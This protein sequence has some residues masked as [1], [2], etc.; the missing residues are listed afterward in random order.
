MRLAHSVRHEVH[1]GIC[2]YLQQWYIRGGNEGVEHQ[3]VRRLQPGEVEP[4]GCGT[5]RLIG[6]L[7]PIAKVPEVAS[8]V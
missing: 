6:R 7:Q 2:K 4:N 8:F 5:Q 1:E 3:R